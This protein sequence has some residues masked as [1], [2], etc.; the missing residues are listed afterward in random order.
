MTA[1][2]TRPSTAAGAARVLVADG[3]RMGCLLLRYILARESIPSDAASTGSEA[4]VKVL[5]RSYDTIFLDLDLP[6]Q[7]GLE[8]CRAVRGIRSDSAPRIILL[9]DHGEDFRPDAA[10]EVGVDQVIFKPIT[11]SEII[12]IARGG[13]D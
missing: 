8:V 12:G 9:T 13:A 6:D 10:A 4:I 2:E 1:R 3:T 7:G 5:E 11:P